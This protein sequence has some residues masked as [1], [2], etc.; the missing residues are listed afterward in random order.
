MRSYRVLTGPTASGKTDW[1]LKRAGEVPIH[2]ISADSRQVYRHMD[3]GTGKPT[4]AEL[5]LLPHYGIDMLNPGE[6][7]S[8]HEFILMAAAAFVELGDFAGEVWVCGGTGLYIRTLVEGLPLGPPPRPQLRAAL[9]PMLQAR[10]SS[11]VA[12]ELALDLRETHNPVRVMRK[13]EC[14]ADALL[15]PAYEYAGLDPELVSTDVEHSPEKYD[16]ALTTVKQWRCE[17]IQVL[18]PGEELE[19]RITRRVTSMFEHGLLPEVQTLRQLGYGETAVVAEGI[20]YRE[21]GQTLDGALDRETA[22]RRAIIRTR[23]Y[24]KRQ[25]TYF[26]GRGWY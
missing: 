16:A 18:D 25:R 5:E 15:A 22:I 3:I 26:R 23:Q 19:W 4:A 14:L 17:S 12:R 9:W 13:V 11:R 2:V 6:T 8:A 1:L 24:A 10:G 21:A 20:A 7:F